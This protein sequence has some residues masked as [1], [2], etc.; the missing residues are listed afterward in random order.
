M[1]GEV[2]SIHG[3]HDDV[4]HRVNLLEQNTI[5][6]T[7]ND[8][9]G[10]AIEEI[11]HP[12]VRKGTSFVDDAR[13]L[14]LEY[15]DEFIAIYQ[16]RPDKVNRCGIRINHAYA[17][18]L[19]IKVLQPTSIIESGVNAGQSTYFMRAASPVAHIYPIDPADEPICDQGSRW[20]DSA[21]DQNKST[22]YTGSNFKD[23]GD[24]DWGSKIKSGEMDPQK[25]LVFLDDHCKVFD[26]W[27]VLMRYGFRHV[28]LEDNYK[29]GEGGTA[30]DKLGWTP[31][32]MLARKDADA[33]FLWHS[34]ESYAEF[35]PLVSAILSSGGQAI[36]GDRVHFQHPLD[37]NHD[38][39]AP[40]LRPETSDADRVI[41]EDI[42]QRLGVDPKMKDD[43]SFMQILNYNQITYMELRPGS[44]H[45]FSILPKG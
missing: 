30:D 34:L 21:A 12:L 38:I 11:G 13:K 42:C 9:P 22:Y 3:G 37:D 36:D 44:P 35:P 40:L 5:P 10:V 33:Q 28:M 26:R 23:L 19:T 14:F 8:W 29:A 18:F 7:M 24:I 43:E 4:N 45:L 32:Q 17:L 2:K 15:L 20:I 25:T 6:P 39:N 31:K 41:Y 16:A 27:N 1:I